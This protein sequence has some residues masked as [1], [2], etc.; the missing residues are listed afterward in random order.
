[1]ITSE[2]NPLGIDGC[3]S[4]TI[5]TGIPIPNG[6][7]YYYKCDEIECKFDPT[8]KQTGDW[9]PNCPPGEVACWD[10]LN[11]ITVSV[12]STMYYECSQYS[13]TEHDGWLKNGERDPSCWDF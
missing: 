13:C 10:W 11:N 9:I 4:P 5:R 1:E 7:E 3:W 6:I 2:A 12:G 8:I